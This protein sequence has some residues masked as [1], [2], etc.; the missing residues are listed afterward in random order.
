MDSDKP[1]VTLA[2]T[3]YN[4]EHCVRDA[5]RGALSQTYEPL[6]IIISDDCSTDRTW[7]IV[8]EEVEAYKKAGGP[9]KNIVLNR[10]ETNLGISRHSQKMLDM[11]HGVLKVCNAGD[12][13][14]L[15]ERVSCIVDAWNESSQ[16]ATLIMSDAIVIDEKGREVGY[17]KCRFEYGKVPLIKGAI[18]AYKVDTL[19]KS[20]LVPLENVYEDYIY[21]LRCSLLGSCVC[22]HKGLLKYRLG[23]VSMPESLDEMKIKYMKMFRTIFKT[24]TYLGQEIEFLK[25]EN[26]CAETLADWRDYI[27]EKKDLCKYKLIR[28]EGGGWSDRVRA[29]RYRTRYISRIRPGYW[30]QA[31][32]L[33][34]H[35]AFVPIAWIE[36][37]L[38]FVAKRKSRTY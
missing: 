35:F 23:G 10:N 30:R 38:A 19:R 27:N 17:L 22:I 33:L 2:M 11:C 7:E 21:E 26:I 34:P 28:Y 16:Q 6:E 36:D 8:C 32:I 3:T 24:L 12:D 4:H 18:M 14:S 31:L 13:I 9:H 29:F 5:V 25:D 15:P 20:S 1:L 37:Y